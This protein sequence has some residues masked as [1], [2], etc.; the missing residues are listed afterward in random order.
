MAQ[1]IT[2]P[3]GVLMQRYDRF[4][5]AY[6]VINNGGV[7]APY[8]NGNYRPTCVDCFFD[9]SDTAFLLTCICY[10][11]DGT[12]TLAST[13]LNKLIWNHNGSLGCYNH[14]GNYTEVGPM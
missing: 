11:V 12:V 7:L 2:A 14:V 3:G 1:L 8:Y 9:G 4:D 6:C 10:N 13:D 5:T